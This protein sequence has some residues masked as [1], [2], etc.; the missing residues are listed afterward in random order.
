MLPPPAHDSGSGW[1]ATPFLYGSCIR[2]SLPVYPGAFTCPA[3][4]PWIGE[5]TD[6]PLTMC[7]TDIYTI[8]AN[9]AGIPGISIPC[10]FSEAGLPIGLQL[11]GKHFDEATLLQIA[12]AY[13]QATD[14]HVRRPP[15]TQ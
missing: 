10:G 8:S 11:I 12:D 1:I 2:D 7:L 13:Q 15:M 4:M 6:D 3:Y 5:K 14:W 9:L